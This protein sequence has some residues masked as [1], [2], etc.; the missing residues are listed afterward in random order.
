M[1]KQVIL[2]GIEEYLEPYNIYFYRPETEILAGCYLTGL[3]MDGERKSVEPM[4][5]KVNAPERSMQR[6]LSKGVWD[7]KGVAKT[8]RKKMLALTTDQ[9]GILIIDDIGFPKKGK[10]SACVSRQYCGATGKTDNCQI[11]VSMSYVGQGVS[12]PYIMELYVP[13]TWDQPD[14]DCIKR[15]QQTCMPELARYK[16]KWKMALDFIDLARQ[17]NV[18]HRA[19]VADGWYGNI[20]DFRKGLVERHENYILGVYSNSEVFL[21]KPDIVNQPD[22]NPETKD[23]KH[24][25][26]TNTT[27]Q[28]PVKLSKLGESIALDAWQRMEL[29]CNVENK[30]LVVEAVAMRVWPA[31]G[32]RNGKYNEQVWVMI[33]R[34]A[35]STG[36]YELRY[37]YSNMSQNLATIDLARTYHERFWIEQGYQQLKEELGLD[38]HEG[39][40]W[41]GWHRHV[42]LTF[43]AFGYLTEAR[44]SQKKEKNVIARNKWMEKQNQSVLEK[45]ALY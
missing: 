22:K 29:R 42:L 24:K 15:R 28:K 41:P 13:E 38:H 16:E 7:E 11:G 43:L 9:Q 23:R 37:F 20:P 18:P 8:Y 21:E 35:L 30:P 25:K 33:E 36:K 2:P 12:W 4:S 27:Q 5:E 31:N 19:I 40:S 44:L 1:S 39:R 17:D 26:V 34:R 14:E 10:H 6:F 3:L 45:D 32:W